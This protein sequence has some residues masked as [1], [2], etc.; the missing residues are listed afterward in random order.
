MG[1]LVSTA[2]AVEQATLERHMLSFQILSRSLIAAC[3][4]FLVLSAQSV[5]A[6]GREITVPVIPGSTSHINNDYWLVARED[7][8]FINE[9]VRAGV[10]VVYGDL[11]VLSVGEDFLVVE[12]GDVGMGYPDVR[13]N[14][15]F[16]GDVF[17]DQVVFIWVEDGFVWQVIHPDLFLLSLPAA[18]EKMNSSITLI[19]DFTSEK[20]LKR[21]SNGS[22]GDWTYYEPNA[23]YTMFVEGGTAY[24]FIG[25]GGRMH[26]ESGVYQDSTWSTHAP[27]I[28]RLLPGQPLNLAGKYIQLYYNRDPGGIIKV[29]LED[30]NGNRI[31][32][33]WYAPKLKGKWF[34]GSFSVDNDFGN[35]DASDSMFPTK[36]KRF[37]DKDAHQL[38]WRGIRAHL[39]LQG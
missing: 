15:G 38:V 6:T 22:W 37:F 9:E 31:S 10:D 17:L 33:V 23:I 2:D 14:P 11:K 4:L 16:F 13:E 24:G 19:D 18:P 28:R 5:S 1:K 20:G 3:F 25:S 12:V 34:T 8:V 30:K 27:Q 36:D 7:G 32:T 35:N 29:K 21:E 26:R 39:L